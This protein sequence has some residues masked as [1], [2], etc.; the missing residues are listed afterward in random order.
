MRKSFTQLLLCIVKEIQRT[1][2]EENRTL[3]CQALSRINGVVICTALF[4]A[5]PIIMIPGARTGTSSVLM[6]EFFE[7]EKE[8]K[9]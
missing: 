8:T 7:G 9:V 4:D 3:P 2:L 5:N 1:Y 6:K